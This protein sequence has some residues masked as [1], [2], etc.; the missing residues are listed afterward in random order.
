MNERIVAL[1]VGIVVLAAAFITGFLII[2]LGEG[3]SVWQ[4]RY[5]IFLKFPKAPGVAIDT[6]VRK[7]GVLIGR[8]TDIELLDA[9]GV[10]VTARIDAD[11]KL[12]RN[13]ICRIS[14]SSLLGDAV[15]EFVPVDDPS[16][17]RTPVQDGDYI[18]DTVVASDPIAVLTNLEGDVRRAIQ[19]FQ[20]ASETVS[21]MTAR[22]NNSLGSEDQ[23]PR[24][25]QKTELA[26]DKFRM[27]METVDQFLGDPQLRDQLKQGLNDLPHTLNEMRLTMEK[28]RTALDGFQVVQQKIETNLDNISGFTGP[29]G[30]RG[31]EMVQKVDSILTNVNVMAEEVAGLAQNVRNSDG[32]LAKLMRDDQLYRKLDGTV[33]ELRETVRRIR[34]ILDDVRVFSDKIARDPRQLGVKGA[35]GGPP[36]GM[37]FKGMMPNLRVMESWSPDGGEE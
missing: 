24:L 3:Q 23:L 16:L 5:T 33:D 9:G 32:T 13:E 28:A 31:P 27:S 14:S 17:P 12:Y 11:R 7:H 19:S 6:P 36:T 25:L 30:E 21:V 37:G 4:R 1:R 34:P 10:E 35:I 2:L 29:L 20:T 15:L 26:L 22:L 18:A 8:V